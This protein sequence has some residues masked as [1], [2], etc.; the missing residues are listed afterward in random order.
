MGKY[1]TRDF[2]LYEDIVLEKID[3]NRRKD[4]SRTRPPETPLAEAI[5]SGLIRTEGHEEAQAQLKAHEIRRG[6][7]G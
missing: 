1:N 7:P 3:K 5:R 4:R 2:S 6:V